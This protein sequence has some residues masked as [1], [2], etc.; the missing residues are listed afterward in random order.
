MPD[1]KNQHY[2]PRCH[3]K[4]FSLNGEGAAINVFNLPLCRP[5]QNAA[6][7]GQCA[8][9]YIY[10]T[11]LGLEKSLQDLE[12]QYANVVRVIKDAV[13][14]PSAKELG[15]LRGFALLQYQ[16]TDMAARRTRAMHEG[17]HKAIY[18]G[19]RVRNVPELDLSRRR[20]MLETLQM[21]ARVHKVIDDLKICIINNGTPIDFVTSD[22]P[23]V[24]VSKFLAQREKTNNFGM[25]SSGVLFFLPLTPRHCLMCY[26][27]DVYRVPEKQGCLLP[28]TDAYDALA[29][30]ELQFLKAAESIYFSRWDDRNYIGKAIEAVSRRRPKRWSRFATFVPDGK[31]EFGERFRLATDGERLTA[32]EAIVTFGSLHPVPATWISKLKYRD[33]VRTY[34]RGTG[35]GLVRKSMWETRGNRESLP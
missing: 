3:L 30:N 22:D 14:Q 19:R 8:K 24:M 17:L 16:R 21:W 18:D 25:Q 11:N 7:R 28:I 10:G 1:H 12:G 4:P 5:I 13:R 29:V 35:A 34:G 2:V 20:M 32:R 23:S 33:P 6:V 31:T 15:L 26:D 9:H 27:G